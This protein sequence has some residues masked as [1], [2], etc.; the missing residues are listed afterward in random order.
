MAGR[1]FPYAMPG[2]ELREKLAHKPNFSIFYVLQTLTDAFLF[3]GLS[4]DVPQLLVLS[5][6][7]DS[8]DSSSSL[9]AF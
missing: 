6:I 4:G 8:H 5:V 7:F 9:G 2:F 3:I 1:L